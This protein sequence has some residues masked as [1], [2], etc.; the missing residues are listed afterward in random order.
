MQNPKSDIF[1][2]RIQQDLAQI[3]HSVLMYYV[4]DHNVH[5][6]LFYLHLLTHTDLEYIASNLCQFKLA[7][8]L[9]HSRKDV[10]SQNYQPCCNG[11]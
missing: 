10:F 6:P 1:L 9:A 5:R 3:M 2:T 7:S 8:L 4:H 11:L